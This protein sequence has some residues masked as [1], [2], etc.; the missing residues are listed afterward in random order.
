MLKVSEKKIAP[1][2]RTV[3][4]AAVIEKSKMSNQSQFTIGRVENVVQQSKEIG[5]AARHVVGVRSAEVT[6]AC[7]H[8]WVATEGNG[9]SSVIGGPIVTCPVCKASEQVH[10]RLF[11]AA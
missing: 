8:Q 9:L 7:E 4:P 11:N 10:M 5:S 1:I 3:R 6:C 2:W